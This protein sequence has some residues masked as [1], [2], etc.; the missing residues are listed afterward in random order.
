MAES[1]GTD[2]DR[3]RELKSITTHWTTISNPSR[4]VIRYGAAVRAYLRA[5]LPTRD[6]ADEVEQK[7]LLQ[8]VEKGFPTA[9]PGRGHFRHYLITIV[10]NAAFGHLRRR[11]KQVAV[12]ADLSQVP[13]ADMADREWQN[14]WRECVLQNTWN[15]LRDHQKTSK[16]NQFHTVLKAFVEHQQEDSPTLAARVSK[17]TG[18]SLSAE[19]FRKQ[20]SGARR[21][22]RELLIEEV[23]RTITNVTPELLAEELRDL[24]LMK[25]VKGLLPETKR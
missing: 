25:Y 18:Q 4:F 1:N 19:A 21:R 16:G 6:D 9:A 13:A 14:S 2:S 17:S 15:A 8:V 20:L 11:S 24:D 7:F 5:L 3:P 23:S 12:W 22:F 10:K